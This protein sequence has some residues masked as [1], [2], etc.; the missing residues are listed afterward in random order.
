MTRC[1]CCCRRRL[2]LD[3]SPQQALCSALGDLTVSETW[4]GFQGSKEGD[5]GMCSWVSLSSLSLSPFHS[6]SGDR[7]TLTWTEFLQPLS[8]AP[9]P[10]Q[11]TALLL[12]LGLPRWDLGSG[13]AA[14]R[15]GSFCLGPVCMT[16]CPVHQLDCCLCLMASSRPKW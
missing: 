16:K 8:T 5:M 10:N 11:S 7:C 2:F 9:P 6:L 4:P 12:I 15:R 3:L 1:L 13:L 14:R